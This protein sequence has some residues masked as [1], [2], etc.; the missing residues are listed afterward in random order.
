MIWFSWSVLS[1][2]RKIGMPLIISAM[3]HPADHTSMLVEYVRLPSKTSGAR[4]HSVTTSFE[5][6][7]TGMP[8]AR[9]RPKSAS[10]SSPRLLIKRFC[11]LRSRCSTRFSW[12]NAVPLSSW[13]MKLRT[14]A[15][16]SAPR[17]PW[18]SM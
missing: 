13:N 12:Q 6:V 14:V 8:N 18:T 2:P 3:M 1:R 11:G 9:A 16:S 5:K 10:L 15:G 17:L 7:L 4:Y